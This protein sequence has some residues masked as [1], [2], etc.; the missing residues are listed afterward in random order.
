[1]RW[2][3]QKNELRFCRCEVIK[4]EVNLGISKNF[5][6]L[7]S[8]STGDF[9]KIIAADDMLLLDAIETECKYLQS[10]KESK[11]TWYSNGRVVQ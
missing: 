1:M 10:C 9:I 11:G 3:G 7:V 8:H 2:S 6:K 5:N 4:N